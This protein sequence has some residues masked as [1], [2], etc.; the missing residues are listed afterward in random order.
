MKRTWTVLLT[1]VVVGVAVCA[2]ACRSWFYPPEVRLEERHDTAGT[3]VFDHSDFD[4]LLSEIVQGVGFVDYAGV[5]QRA[6]RLDAYLARLAEAPYDELGRDAKLALWINAYNACTLKLIA[7]RYPLAS[8]KDIP[9][10]ERWDA[11]RW[12]VGG[13]TLSLN[14]I[15]HEQVRAHFRE[16]RIHFALVC[17]SVGCHGFGVRPGRRLR[18]ASAD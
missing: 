10:V 12:T 7:E 16:P 4:A 2:V 15:E 17:A 3:A 8:I 5:Q 13:R 11:V 1:L 6:E 9:A 18:H 14:Q